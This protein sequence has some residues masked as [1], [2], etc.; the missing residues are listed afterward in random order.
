SVE[1]HRRP[2]PGADAQDQVSREVA[3]GAV[4]GD[5][6]DPVHRPLLGPG[7]GAG[8]PP[9]IDHLATPAQTPDP[10]GGPATVR[11][12]LGP[13]R[14]EVFTDVERENG[15]ASGRESVT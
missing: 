12:V 1:V 6:G 9:D 13:Q 4:A 8:L 2:R 10:F 5:R 11:V 3:L 15:R 14:L 7:H